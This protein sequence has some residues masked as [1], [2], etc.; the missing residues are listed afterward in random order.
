MKQEEKERAILGL[1]QW[2]EREKL[3]S[4]RS[5]PEKWTIDTEQAIS[6]AQAVFLIPRSVAEDLT[7]SAFSVAHER[8]LKNRY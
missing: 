5:F 6:Y 8:Y 4:I 3:S 7:E 1:V 2:I